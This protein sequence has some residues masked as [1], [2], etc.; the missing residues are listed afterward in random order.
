M[1]WSDPNPEMVNG[2]FVPL[3]VYEDKNVKKAIAEACGKFV[4]PK[5]AD[6]EE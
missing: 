4:E 3:A 2:Y 6:P 5:F 1:M